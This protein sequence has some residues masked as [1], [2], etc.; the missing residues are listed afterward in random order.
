MSGETVF[1]P[2]LGIGTVPVCAVKLGRRGVGVEFSQVL[3]A[4]C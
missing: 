3:K 4:Q 1:D 2:F